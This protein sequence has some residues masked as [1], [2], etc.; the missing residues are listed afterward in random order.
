MDGQQHVAGQPRNF[1]DAAA[2]LAVPLSA[3]RH[4]PR[5]YLFA[6][7]LI[8]ACPPWS[9]SRVAGERG[10]LVVG[11]LPARRRV[12]AARN[13]IDHSVRVAVG[14]DL[15]GRV[16]G[17]RLGADD[18][19][20][21]QLHRVESSRSRSRGSSGAVLLALLALNFSI[22]V[23][24]IAFESRAVESFFYAVLMFSPILC[25]GLL[26]GSAIK[27]STVA[28]ARLRHQPPRRDGWRR[29]RVSVAGDRF[30]PAAP[31]DRPCY[32]AA[33]AAR[34]RS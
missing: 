10:T 31:R 32:L 28:P 34:P 30:P 12:H 27:R 26:F 1:C 16:A 24:R 8:L 23:G 14:I 21:C 7:A 19:A 15:G 13:E 33:L 3:D 2:E 9:C 18:G 6:L 20:R 22:P 4:I 25:A 17:D 5:H 11:I 29:R